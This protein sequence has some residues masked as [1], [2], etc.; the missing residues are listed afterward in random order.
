MDE[1]MCAD[2]ILGTAN[3]TG[4]FQPKRDNFAP[5]QGERD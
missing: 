5:G 2:I 3:E 1:I 4:F